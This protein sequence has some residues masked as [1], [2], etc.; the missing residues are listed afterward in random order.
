MLRHVGHAALAKACRERYCEVQYARL[1]T[2]QEV[3]QAPCQVCEH[4]LTYYVP[5]VLPLG[6]HSLQSCAH[7][8][9]SHFPE[10]L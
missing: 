3:I 1:A 5:V 10:L 4:L 9:V 7:G 6:L 2:F 8:F